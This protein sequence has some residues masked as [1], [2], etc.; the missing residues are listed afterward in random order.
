MPQRRLIAGHGSRINPHWSAFMVSVLGKRGRGLQGNG[1]VVMNRAESL[2]KTT[3]Q[4]RKTVRIS[5]R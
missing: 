2:G 5:P 4:R 3:I 1:I